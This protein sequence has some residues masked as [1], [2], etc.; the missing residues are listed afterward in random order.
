MERIK[1]MRRPEFM[2]FTDKDGTLNLADRQ[3]NSIIRL[4]SSMG[5]MV[6]PVTGRTVGD[7]KEDFKKRKI[8][9]PKLIV[10]DNGA[11][12]YWTETDEF[13]IRKTLAPEKIEQIIGE[14]LKIGGEPNLIRYTDGENIYA[15]GEDRVKA[16]Y[17]KSK[18]A[19]ILENVE[20]EIL[21]ADDITKI[22][23]A[24]TRKQ[25][26]DMSAY[27]S[28]LGFWTDLDRTKFPLATSENYRLDI[29]Q[30]GINKGEA[31]KAIV[32]YFKPRYGYICVGNG[33][34]DLAMF[35][36]AIDN[37]MEADIMGDADQE[38]IENLKSY[39]RKKKK[40]K[41]FVIPRD[42][43][44]ANRIILRRAKLFQQYIRNKRKM[45]TERKRIIQSEEAKRSF[46]NVKIRGNRRKNG[47]II[48]D[49][50]AR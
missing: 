43:N 16:Y 28:N 23:L 29:A 49:D 37:G 18:V 9:L 36:Q 50:G 5:G 6:V 47:R 11:N 26:E 44:K 12:V 17:S 20:D 34:N 24:G 7:I 19:K 41:V 3:L 38:L 39:S 35:K 21:Q 2:I 1:K 40:G 48:T 15:S 8:A 27:V 13:I 14:Y 32:S 10:G 30:K 46:R 45:P 25:M 31:V 33:N 22:T 42:K 4:I